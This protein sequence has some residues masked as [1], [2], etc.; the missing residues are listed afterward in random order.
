MKSAIQPS[1]PS[2]SCPVAMR[3]KAERPQGLEEINSSA[4]RLVCSSGIHSRATAIEA[5]AR[6]LSD[7]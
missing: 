4:R 1:M 7:R 3:S 6:S 2:K 5:S